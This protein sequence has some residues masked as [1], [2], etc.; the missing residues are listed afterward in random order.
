MMIYA[1]Q[2]LP[3]INGPQ[4]SC[5]YET[6]RWYGQ[7]WLKRRPREAPSHGLRL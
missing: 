2:F 1:W 6:K 3:E 5:R 4:A 7:C